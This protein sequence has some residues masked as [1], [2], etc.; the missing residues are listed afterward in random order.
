V[1]ES[2]HPFFR[3]DG[4]FPFDALCCLAAVP[5]YKGTRALVDHFEEKKDAKNP[6][7]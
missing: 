1:I 2:R 5:G 7:Q 3:P 6:S 4:E